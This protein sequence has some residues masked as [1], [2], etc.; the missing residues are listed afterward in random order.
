[1]DILGVT[2]SAVRRV[3]EE[4]ITGSLPPGS[5]LNETEISDRLGISR[6]PLREA[7]RILGN[8]MLLE[9]R[10]RRGTFVAPMSLEDC[11]QICWA[12]R[13]L[14]CAAI[15]SLTKERRTFGPLRDAWNVDE[16]ALK[17]A[18]IIDDYYA[19]SLFHVR[20]IE[21]AENR[22]LINCH[23]CLQSSLARYQVMYLNLPGSRARSLEEHGRILLSIEEG[24]FETAKRHLIDHLER[25]RLALSGAIAERLVAA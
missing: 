23:Q 22:W 5:R 24:D 3:R 13:V 18:S 8:E 6:P 1:M 15:D 20:L 21:A 7:L 16:S 17:A 14:E 25:I 4:I 11:D 2:A 9:F 10:P 19:M 12:R